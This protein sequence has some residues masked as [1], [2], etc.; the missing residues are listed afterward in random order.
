MFK[1]LRL[2]LIF[3]ETCERGYISEE[4]HSIECYNTLQKI[5][6]LNHFAPLL[7]VTIRK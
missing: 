7:R 3:I 6:K 1:D 5:N 4:L 2:N